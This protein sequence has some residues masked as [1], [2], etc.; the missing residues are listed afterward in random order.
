MIFPYKIIDLT[1]TLDEQTPSWSGGCGFNIEVK[2]DYSD[3]LQNEEFRV[4]QFKMH[5]GIGTHMDAPAHC[6]PGSTTIDQILLSQLI[7]PCVVIDV[8]SSCHERYSLSLTDIERFEGQY[9]VINE[10]SFVM[11]KTG[12]EK[13]WGDPEKYRNN[14]V[15]P[16]ISV[17]A[18]EILT[19][20][21]VCG[22]GI[23]TLSPDRP[24]DGFPVHKL[25]L[26][27]GKY[28]VENVANLA[29]L[30]IIGSCILALPIKVRRATEA[31][32]RLI[33]LIKEETNL[34]F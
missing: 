19:K 5:A 17:E 28:I 21:G 33:G 10:G 14:H 26:G 9:G 15:F 34:N 16:S 7:A 4:Q 29:S 12:W 31:P 8:S 23:D 6:I 2:L 27:N 25:F 3:C 1:H 11:I 18:A 22:L 20:R 13:F 32:I 24:A 30:P